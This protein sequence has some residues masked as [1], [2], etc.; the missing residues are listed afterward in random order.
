MSPLSCCPGPP[1]PLVL[2]SRPSC[3]PRPTV[4]AHLST[5][6]CCP[7]PPVPLVLLSRPSCPPRPAVPASCPPRPAVA[8]HLSPSSYCPGPPAPLVLLS[9]PSCP[10]RPAVPPV[11]KLF[12]P[13]LTC[14]LL[15]QVLKGCRTL[16]MTVCSLG[17]IP[18]GHI[19]NH[20]YSWVDPQGRSVSPPPDPE[21]AKPVHGASVDERTV[22]T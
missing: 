7:G 11:C 18:G 10:P 9:R 16:A 22:G 13:C 2:L 1:A 14:V 6:S 4:L 8:A 5:S 3:P 20:L 15:D 12:S 19:T 21:E 17:H